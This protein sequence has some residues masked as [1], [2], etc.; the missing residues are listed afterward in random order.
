MT[1][2]NKVHLK[3]AVCAR[4]PGPDEDVLL[5]LCKCKGR[6]HYK[7][8]CRVKDK[9]HVPDYDTTQYLAKPKIMTFAKEMI[10]RRDKETSELTKQDNVLY[11]L[12]LRIG[13]WRKPKR[14]RYIGVFVELAGLE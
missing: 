9:V 13:F 14:S 12:I 4:V 2:N 1:K 3:C 6:Y 8:A 11:H 7:K 5:V 10:K